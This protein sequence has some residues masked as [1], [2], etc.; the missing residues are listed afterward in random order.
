MVLK[1]KDKINIRIQHMNLLHISHRSQALLLRELYKTKACRSLL[2]PEAVQDFARSNK[3]NDSDGSE[4]EDWENELEGSH[5]ASLGSW[6]A[7]F[8]ACPVACSYKFYLHPRL[9]LT[10]VGGEPYGL[11]VVRNTLNTFQVQNRSNMFVIEEQSTKN[12]F[13]LRLRKIQ[14]HQE[15]MELDLEASLS[16]SN[17][18]SKQFSQSKKRESD[19]DSLTSSTGRQSGRVDEVVE[20]TVHGITD[21]GADI[22][23]DLMQLLQKRL[24][25]AVLDAICVMLSRN[26]LCKLKRDDVVFIQKPEAEPS[27]TILLTIPGH[28][29]SYLMA[30]MYYLRQNLLQFLHTP[31]YVN[32]NP[33]FQFQVSSQA[34]LLQLYRSV[35]EDLKSCACVH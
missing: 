27:K 18:F 23:E 7:G 8:F 14:V 30:L 21:V 24:D 19:T 26:P 2:V 34:R 11:L 9:Q 28:F 16:D 1:V 6:P 20:L 25:D 29:S 31:N 17:Q 13:Y 15:K 22:K 5:L 35:N 33:E 32:S 12:V 10:K 4:E 3:K